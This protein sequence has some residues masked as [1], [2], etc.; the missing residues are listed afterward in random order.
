MSGTKHD[1]AKVDMSLLSPFA[2]EK[3]AQVMTFGKHKYTANN[4]RKGFP[5]TRLI[6]AVKRHINSYEKGE[7][8]DPETGL[9]HLAHA[10]CGLMMLLEFEETMPELNDVYFKDSH[11]LTEKEKDENK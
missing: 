2:I 7:F 5:F 4:W 11:K 10:S 3:I 9:S 1:D 8:L 6:A